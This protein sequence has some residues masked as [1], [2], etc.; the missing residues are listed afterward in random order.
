[1]KISSIQDSDLFAPLPRN[2]IFI[3][4]AARSQKYRSKCF[5]RV[6]R[7]LLR[8]GQQVQVLLISRGFTT[9]EVK[10]RRLHSRS[11]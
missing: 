11:A 6:R 3:D 8:H 1:M 7:K 5:R 2:Y 9:G 4:S 10:R